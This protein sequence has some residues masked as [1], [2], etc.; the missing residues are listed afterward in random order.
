MRLVESWVEVL[1]RRPQ[2]AQRDESINV[3]VTFRR[4]GRTGQ[5]RRKCERH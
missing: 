1:D 5:H 4:P 3:V 2:L